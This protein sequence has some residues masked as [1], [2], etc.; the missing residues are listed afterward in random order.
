MPLE[1]Q[2]QLLV[3]SIIDDQKEERQSAADALLRHNL[4]GDTF[5]KS[6]STNI[7]EVYKCMPQMQY[8]VV[9]KK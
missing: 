6:V 1:I 9:K 2:L 5:T 3:Q 4:S 7:Y 8:H